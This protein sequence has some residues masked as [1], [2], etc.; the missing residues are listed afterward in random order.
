MT[1]VKKPTISEMKLNEFPESIIG[2]QSLIAEL[3]KRAEQEPD[4]EK[5]RELFLLKLEMRDHIIQLGLNKKNED[6]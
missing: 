5:R 4:K 3:D 1:T 2:T 6:V